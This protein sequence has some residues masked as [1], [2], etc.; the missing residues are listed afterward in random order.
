MSKTITDYTAAGS[1]DASNDYLLIEQTG[2]YHKINR[3]VY[4]GINGSPVGTSDSQSLSNKTIGNTNTVALKD[5]LFTVQDD[6]DATKL[7]AF[8]LSGITTG[9]T[10]TL[11]VPDASLTLVGTATTQTL[12]N[13]T[14]T[15]PA[16]TGG[17]IDNSTITVDSISGHTS[18]TI[19]TVA[20]L[21]ISNGVLNTSNSVVTANVAANAI[22]APKLALGIP[23]QVVSSNTS[24]VASGTTQIPADDTIPQITEGTEFMTLAITPKT[25]TNILIIEV[26]IMLSNSTASRD[27]IAALYQD[28]TANALAAVDT[29]QTTATGIATLSF[30]YRMAAGTTSS[31]TFRVRG[32]SG[33]SGTVTFNGFSATRIFGGVAGSSMVITEYGA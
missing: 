2:V 21:Q 19:V 7:I 29:F 25:T 31:T 5:T 23:V 28:S 8:Q 16:I 10:R 26:T 33:G 3:T 14:I 11:T 20:N 12:T 27:L 32:G 1:I 30:K 18:G 17:T 13:K 4:L 9:N 22:T 6:S 24:S 15:S